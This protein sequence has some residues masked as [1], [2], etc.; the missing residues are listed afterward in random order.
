MFRLTLVIATVLFMTLTGAQNPQPTTP[1]TTSDTTSTWRAQEKH[2]KNVKM[3]TNGG[4]NA[5]AYFSSKGD[6][7]IYQTS[8]PPYECDQIFL[9]NSDGSDKHLVS[10]G[11]GR[12][13]CSFIAPDYQ[14]I[15]YASTH[16]TD[17][18]C[19]P[20]P[21]FSKGYVWALFDYEIYSA[22]PDGSDL[23]NITN[24]LGYDAE[25]VYSPDGSKIVFT[26]K[27]S[28]DLEIYTMNPDGSDVKQLTHELGYDGGPFFSHD[29]KQ[30]VY[31]A[32]RPKTAKDSADYV[33]LLKQNLVRPSELEIYIMNADGTNKRQITHLGRASFAP[34]LHPDGKRLAFCT[35]YGGSVREF[36][37]Y[38]INVDGTGLER[39]TYNPTFD[40]FPMWSNDGKR[41][42]FCSNRDDAKPGETNVFIAD[43]VD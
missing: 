24:S 9:M 2:L 40:G 39:V 32:S 38:L 8:H 37:I 18:L 43:W 7:L 21:D 27:R 10:T 1:A 17:T 29:G 22:K 31:R 11:K 23:K 35:N 5:E 36:N 42:V 16:A 13:T 15:I 28:G 41:F 26:S 6:M 34:F 33:D 19:P 14:R 3:L 25:A 12:T 20:K 30:I 4:E